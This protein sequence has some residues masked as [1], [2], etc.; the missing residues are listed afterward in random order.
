MEK[1]NINN[2]FEKY[3]FAKIIRKFYP[4]DKYNWQ[5]NYNHEQSDIVYSSSKMINDRFD[6]F[7]DKHHI[8]ATNTKLIDQNEEIRH[9]PVEQT[10]QK[11]ISWKLYSKYYFNVKSDALHNVRCKFVNPLWPF[12][13]GILGNCWIVH[14]W[15]LQ[16]KSHQF[17]FT[18]KNF[19]HF[20][21]LF[22]FAKLIMCG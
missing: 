20:S 16:Q 14:A 19:I 21:Y 3:S 15:H 10:K 2:Y 1:K 22:S 12:E 9:M 4:I 5:Q 13:Q 18:V 8:N 11:N 6:I 17:I 7:S